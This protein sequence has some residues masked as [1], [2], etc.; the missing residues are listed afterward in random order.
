MNR[1]TMSA[2]VRNMNKMDRVNK[3]LREQLAETSRPHL[4]EPQGAPSNPYEG[5]IWIC[6]D[7]KVTVWKKWDG[8]QWVGF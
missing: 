8:E 5:Q 4:P 3:R 7:D 1:R 6:R 2:I